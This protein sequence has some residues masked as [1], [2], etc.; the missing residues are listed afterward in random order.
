GRDDRVPVPMMT[1]PQAME[2]GGTMK[3]AVLLIVGIIAATIVMVGCSH[4]TTQT[5][6]GPATNDQAVSPSA[7][8]QSEPAPE[9]SFNPCSASMAGAPGVRRP[10]GDC[11]PRVRIIGY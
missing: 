11:T 6:G 10:F 1:I 7:A 5:A 3:H 2:R 8:A 9:Q 4:V